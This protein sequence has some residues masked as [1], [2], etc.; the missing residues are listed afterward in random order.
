MKQTFSETNNIQRTYIEITKL[1]PTE[2]CLIQQEWEV[3]FI[4]FA[5]DS[6][7]QLDIF[8]TCYTHIIKNDRSEKKTPLI[9]SGDL[10]PGL[11]N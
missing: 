1:E 7:I 10:K 3:E 5:S 8:F 4:T 2:T 11:I 6:V 9:N